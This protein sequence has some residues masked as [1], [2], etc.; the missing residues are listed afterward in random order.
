MIFFFYKD[1]QMR[2]SR[3]KGYKADQRC[4]EVLLVPSSK[5]KRWKYVSQENVIKNQKLETDN[6]DQEV[7]NSV[8]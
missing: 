6:P 1:T 5:L 7:Y 3:V 2:T 4:L 8:Y